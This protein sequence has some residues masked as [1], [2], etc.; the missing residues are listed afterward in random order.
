[1][2]N[3]LKYVDVNGEGVWD[4]VKEFF[5]PPT[6]L[7]VITS[8]D[9]NGAFEKGAF[10][11]QEQE[12]SLLERYYKTEYVRLPKDAGPEAIR[13]AINTFAEKHGN[14]D[15]LYLGFHGQPKSF[16]VGEGSRLTTSNVGQFLGGLEPSFSENAICLLE[17]CSVMSLVDSGEN[18][19]TALSRILGVDL[20]GLTEPFGGSQFYFNPRT[21][22]VEFAKHRIFTPENQAVS[23]L[24]LLERSLGLQFGYFTMIETSASAFARIDEQPIGNVEAEDES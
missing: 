19:G 21:R 11:N 13:N 1:L 9:W 5:S 15:L 2:N 7:A 20:Q 12:L 18:I 23:L 3:P 10:E 6:A 17:S 8:E 16:L 24:S 14:I 22:R 4:K